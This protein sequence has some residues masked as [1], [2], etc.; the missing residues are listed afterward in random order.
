[1]SNGALDASRTAGVDVKPP[2]WIAIL[3]ASI[4]SELLRSPSPLGRTASC[5]FRP[6]TEALVAQL[7]SRDRGWFRPECADANSGQPRGSCPGQRAAI[8]GSKWMVLVFHC[9]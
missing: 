9:S 3:D 7:K 4:G 1:M 6:S 5:A 8:C 2:L